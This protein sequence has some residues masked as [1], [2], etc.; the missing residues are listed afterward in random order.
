MDGGL[1]MANSINR[2]AY[3]ELHCRTNFSFLR[4]ASHP[5]ELMQQSVALGYQALAITD[6][7]TLGGVVEAHIAA[8]ET[9]A[10]LIIGA[11][12]LP[13]DAPTI[14]VWV[15]NKVGYTNLC[16]LLTTARRRA[17]KGHCRLLW[18]DLADHADGLIAGMPL[19]K[20]KP[21]ASRTDAHQNPP[22]DSSTPPPYGQP[23]P[24]RIDANNE[25][26]PRLWVSPE[27][28]P[29]WLNRYREVFG[30]RFYALAEI[31]QTSHPNHQ[32][33][34]LAQTA[35]EHQVPLVA[36]NDVY[37]HHPSR[38]ILHDVVTAIHERTTVEQLG[39]RRFSNAERYLKSL[40]ELTQLF[41]DY[42][43]AL[44]RTVEIADQCTF[45]MDD[46]KYQYPREACPPG[47]TPMDYLEEITWRGATR[48]YPNGIPPK[49]DQLLRRELSLIRKLNY[50]AYFLTVWDLVEFARSRGILCQGRGSAANSVVCYCLAV[51]EVDPQRIDLVFERFISEERNEAPDIDIDFEHERREEVLQYIYD[52]YGRDHAA[53][54][55]E[56]IRYRPRSAI[57]DVGKALGLSPP[58]IDVLAKNLDHYR[59]DKVKL[60]ERCQEV[61]FNIRSPMGQRL[62]EIVD[63][64]VTFPRHRSQ[65]VGGMVIT[66]RPLSELVP[67]ENASMPGRT[68]LEWDKDDLDDIGILKVDCLGLGMLTCLRKCFD[69][70][71]D[72]C[73]DDLKLSNIPP[74]DPLV[75]KM[76]QDADTL[77]VFQI[78]SRAQMAM[79]PRLK[80]SRFYDLVIE[81]AIV[82]PGP[83][84]GKMVHPYLQRRE[85]GHV[86]KGPTP[87]IE[88]IL[89]PTLGVPL[90]QEQV[91]RLAEV[92]AG[93]SPGE[94]D[95][96]RRAMGSWRKTGLI[97]KFRQKL[98][99]GMSERGLP[100]SFA[101]RIF[102]QIKGFAE[103]G[104]PQSHAASFAL[105]VYASSWL[106][107]YY[108]A[109]FAAGL[110]NSQ[111]MGFYAPSQII[112]DAQRHGVTVL[113]VD[114]N[115]SD[116]DC[117]LEGRDLLPA[118][119]L[120][121]RLIKGLSE[122]GGQ[123]VMTARAKHG[124]FTELTLLK[125]WAGLN[126]HDVHSLVQADALVSLGLDRRGAFWDA[127]G[128]DDQS[129]PLWEQNQRDDLMMTAS[130]HDAIE[131]ADRQQL[132]TASAWQ[133]MLDDFQSLGLSL[134]GHPM[135]FLRALLEKQKVTLACQLESRPSG[136]WL[137]VAGIIIMRQQP[138][139][140]KGVR[141]V[142]LEDET[143]IVNL[144][145]FPDLWEKQRRVARQAIA[146]MAH[147]RLERKGKVIHVIAHR[148][149][150]LTE[151]LSDLPAKSR[152]FR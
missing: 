142:S 140:A 47:K 114:V 110:I 92:A 51:T 80:P 40:E 111:P 130:A 27:D 108:P 3:A 16:Q 56:V 71:R 35:Y 104:F 74:E 33:E 59:S 120:G 2:P 75:Y 29:R 41:A 116:W 45:S 138:A 125:K 34:Y 147:G 100:A 89:R 123:R 39:H 126:Q 146:I 129:R 103:Y 122:G 86:P 94:A 143:G 15:Q 132:P 98:L 64:L 8:Q 22:S 152:D 124:P 69:L 18:K 117:T 66:E 106:K 60:A 78:E 4:G 87:E 20:S 97:E 102:D 10:R 50:E 79:L 31:H 58:T 136:Q 54:T 49:V 25:S 133:Q 67:V 84:Q 144:V 43:S 61:G 42:P 46:L 21:V 96:L 5:V 93:F 150:N 76:M 109:A 63:Q 105:L 62:L 11:E 83:I 99:D 30:D 101:E 82:R 118:L 73:G 135:N 107:R 12:L 151:Y 44:A 113:P 70:I 148:L 24:G 32:L 149:E 55:A 1:L 112:K 48:R 38:Q 85:N 68:V 28:Y 6:Q 139:T 90:F 19:I 145:V 14:V 115:H 134:K 9:N 121:M 36:S 57:R 95:Q 65:H 131:K 127:L 141:F 72:N 88:R 13:I 26:Y 119:R 137:R 81:V 7:N 37:Y 91:M 52:K 23:S 128:Q 77:G 17:D 53:M